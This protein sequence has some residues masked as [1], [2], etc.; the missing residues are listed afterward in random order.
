MVQV[1]DLI[2]YGQCADV[3]LVGSARLVNMIRAVQMALL[4]PQGEIYS[5]MNASSETWGSG[6]QAVKV[7][8]LEKLYWPEAKFSK[9]DMLHY[10]QQIAP[11]ALPYFID[12]PVTLRVFPAGVSGE[13]YYLRD[14]PDSAPDW[15]R[16]IEYRPKTVTHQ[17]PLPLIDNVAGLIWFANQ[18]AIEFHLWGS[19]VPRLTQPDQAIFD[20]DAGDRTSFDAAREAALRLHDRLEKAGMKSCPKTSGRHGL[21]IYV[22]LA[23][24]YTFGQVRGWVK[25]VGQQLAS[26]YPNLISMAG[27]PTHRGD[28]VTVDAAQNSIGRNTAAPYT[29]RASTPHPTVSTPLTWEELEAGT[30]HPAD[31]TPDVVLARVQ[32][33][34]DLFAPVQQLDQ[35]IG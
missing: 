15:L 32:Q 18:G 33:L 6:N 17:V 20:L 10:Y 11:V 27:G 31:L 14:C 24:R 4:V 30:I 7:S 2:Q 13:S 29:L 26:D 3:I 5:S 34:G 25:A 35:N 19:R 1:I 28:R 9:G 12:R 8:H 16:R 23:A 21:H 22:P